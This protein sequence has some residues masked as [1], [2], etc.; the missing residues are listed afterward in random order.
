MKNK[1]LTTIIIASTLVFSLTGTAGACA[2][3]CGCFEGDPVTVVDA[4]FPNNPEYDFEF[5]DVMNVN[6]NLLELESMKDLHKIVLDVSK[7]PNKE[8]KIETGG[9][10]V[11]YTDPTHDNIFIDAVAVDND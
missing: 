11:I 1:I 3:D 7:I 6:E 8:L 10:I 2:C 9:Q 4:F 5:Y